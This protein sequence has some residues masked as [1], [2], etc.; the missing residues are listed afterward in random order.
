MSPFERFWAAWPRSQRKQSKTLCMRKWESM[1]LNI[2]AEEIIRHVEYMKTQE[3]WLKS[4]GSFIP[5]PLVY[6]N[7][8][9]WDGAEVP[10]SFGK[11]DATLAKL[12]EDRKQA[13]PP[14]PEILAQLQNLKK[15]IRMH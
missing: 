1:G 12:A 11:P 15:Q 5:A 14:P 13:A 10:E 7:Q 2:H 4:N 3:A 9:R 8:M 6:I